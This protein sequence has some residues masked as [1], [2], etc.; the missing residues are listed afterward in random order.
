MIRKE[1]NDF[2]TFLYRRRKQAREILEAE[3][4][5]HEKKLVKTRHAIE[6]T[7]RIDSQDIKSI[8]ALQ[9]V[10]RQLEGKIE[11]VKRA[12][13]WKLPSYEEL[14]AQYRKMCAV[15]RVKRVFVEENAICIETECLYGQFYRT[16]LFPWS[17]PCMTWHRIGQ[18]LIWLKL[19]RDEVRWNNLTGT[20]DTM[21]APTGI[22]SN[23]HASCLGTA[24]DPIQSA[25][26]TY[27]YERLASIVVRYAE[28][29]GQDPQRMMLWPTVKRSEV[30]Q[31]YRET[32]PQKKWPKFW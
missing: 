16:G 5:G 10:V 31:W 9:N 21:H 20:K 2:V 17:R 14:R 27:E 26:R 18:F 11:T 22:H 12:P 6:R 3:L 13:A 32:F 28:C 19:D 23:G 8:G 7:P 30:P 29:A 1:E 15:P 24:R 25:F 4:R